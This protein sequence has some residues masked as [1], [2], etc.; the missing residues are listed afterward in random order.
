MGLST[1]LGFGGH[2]RVKTHSNS[3]ISFCFIY[4]SWDPKRMEGR[5]SNPL[6]QLPKSAIAMWGGGDLWV[7]ANL[8]TKEGNQPFRPQCWCPSAGWNQADLSGN[9]FSNPSKTAVPSFAMVL[10]VHGNFLL[11][12][13]LLL[14]SVYLKVGHSLSK[15]SQLGCSPFWQEHAMPPCQGGEGWGSLRLNHSL[16]EIQGK[17]PTDFYGA[18]SLHLPDSSLMVTEPEA[19]AKSPCLYISLCLAD[20]LVGDPCSSGPLASSR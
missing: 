19:V 4:V 15:S 5:K 16:I 1:R 8:Q 6:L 20:F 10:T 14:E 9:C 3:S 18:Q 17:I 7:Q 13:A 2:P 11:P 12:D